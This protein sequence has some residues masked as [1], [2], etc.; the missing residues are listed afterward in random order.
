M[1]VPLKMRNSISYTTSIRYKGMIPLD[2]T[3]HKGLIKVFN[4]TFYIILE[5]MV[6]KSKHTWPDKLLEGL[7]AYKTIIGTVNKATS[8]PT[9]FG[10]EAVLLP[11]RH[12]S[13]M[14]VTI[15]KK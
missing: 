2:T 15:H 3:Y 8:Y 11:E 7:W 1:V 5:K 14:R 13:S 10:G 4:K 12:I 9:V 6:D